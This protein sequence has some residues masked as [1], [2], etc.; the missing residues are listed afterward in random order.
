MATFGTWRLKVRVLSLRL[1]KIIWNFAQ[2]IYLRPFMC[3]LI[4]N[5]NMEYIGVKNV[6]KECKSKSDVLKRLKLHSNGRNNRKLNI[7]IESNSMN[8]THFDKGVSKRVKYKIISRI[9]PVC[10]C[11]FKIK[12]NDDKVTCS[13][14]CSNTYF[15]SGENNPNWKDISEYYH[16]LRHPKLSKKYRE[17]CFNNHKH[18]CVICG[19]DKILDVHHYDGDRTNNK[20]NNLI[21]ICPTHHNYIHFG[22]EHLVIDKLNEYIKNR[23]VTKVE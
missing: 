6:I 1:I 22:Y 16:D 3:I 4:K 21:P 20:P 23:E 13:Y 5:Y 15:R 9:C 10:D 2:T 11:E 19:E 12:E 17:I 7:I 18:E 14:S 8:I